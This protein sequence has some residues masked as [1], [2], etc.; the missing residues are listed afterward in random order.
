MF[1]KIDLASGYH[2]VRI[3]P[4]DVQK[5]AFRTRYGHFEFTVLPF[6][7]CNAPATF[8][9]P[10]QRLMNEV[11]HSYLDE[12]VIVYLDDIAIYSKPH[13]EHLEHLRLTLTKLRESKCAFGVDRMELQEFDFD[14]VHRPGHTNIVADALSRRPDY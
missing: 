7:L 13:D 9:A 6:G 4:A 5:T 3:A 2:Q 1:S 14:I 10:G 8:H 11:L 12:F